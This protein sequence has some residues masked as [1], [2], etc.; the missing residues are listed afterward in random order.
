MGRDQE[1]VWGQIWG[2]EKKRWRILV[3][4]QINQ[5]LFFFSRGCFQNQRINELTQLWLITVLIIQTFVLRKRL[6]AMVSLWVRY[7]QSSTPLLTL[8]WLCAPTFLLSPYSR[9][10]WLYFK[11]RVAV[12][13]IINEK[14]R[15]VL[16]LIE[17]FIAFWKHNY[18]GLTSQHTSLF[19]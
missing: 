7:A 2:R 12:L 19:C 10:T 6:T 9:I 15:A 14:L 16:L 11:W 1:N 13:K 8:M 18:V 17:E 4:L 3:I 5:M